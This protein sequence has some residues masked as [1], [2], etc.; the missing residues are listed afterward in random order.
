MRYIFISSGYCN[1]ISLTGWFKLQKIYF[2]LFWRLEIWHQETSIVGFWCEL[3]F[4]LANSHCTSVSSIGGGRRLCVSSSCKRTNPIKG[5]PSSDPI[6]T[7]LT[8]KAS[9]PN[10]ITLRLGL[11]YMK[12][13]E[14]Q[15]PVHNKVKVLSHKIKHFK[16]NN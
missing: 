16:V 3:S 1:K 5:P 14:T 11:Q 4:W 8:P 2:L 15:I 6:E 7:Y 13:W 12:F 10:S 9:P